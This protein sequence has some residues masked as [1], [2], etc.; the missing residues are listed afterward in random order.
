MIRD[1]RLVALALALPLVLAGC[2]GGS[3]TEP[4]AKQIVA[5]TTK[6]T[7][8][9]KSFRFTLDV[10]GVPASSSGLSLTHAD[11]EVVVPNRVDAKVSGTFFH[12]PLSSELVV[13]GGTDYL[14][15]PLTGHWRTVDIKTSPLTFFDPHGGALAIV[16]GA[17]DLALAGKETVGGVDSYR[18][19]GKVRARDASPL[20]AV[21]TKS[22]RLVGVEFW[23]GAKD[24]LLRRVR[25]DGPVAEGEPEGAS[26]TID[27]SD[28]GASFDIQAPV[29]G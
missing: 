9:V 23:I 7:A 5:G 4:G 13:V 8:A 15:D 2:G 11:G 29:T 6:T 26:R 24:M 16:R 17:K 19:T 18:L 10:S 20:L 25:V 12:I 1:V 22:D 21:S 14:K 3:S 28:F 27:L